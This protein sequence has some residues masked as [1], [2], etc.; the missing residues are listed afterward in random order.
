MKGKKTIFFGTHFIRHSK[1][2]PSLP[3][4][5]ERGEVGGMLKKNSL[6]YDFFKLT[7]H[8]NKLSI[9]A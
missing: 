2:V 8:I 1:T 4:S 5:K 6:S 3:I 9:D 7:N